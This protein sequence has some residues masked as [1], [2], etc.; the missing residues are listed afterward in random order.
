MQSIWNNTSTLLDIYIFLLAG[1]LLMLA[2]R[3]YHILMMEKKAVIKNELRV[4][5]KVM[6][7]FIL[8]HSRKW[9]CWC[10]DALLFNKFYLTPE[11][12]N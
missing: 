9:P 8:I 2:Q 4:G 5:Q 1:H 12:R 6:K 10:F 3:A 7:I 11:A